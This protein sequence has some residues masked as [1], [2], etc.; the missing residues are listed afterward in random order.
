MANLITNRL[1]I[2]G[3]NEQIKEVFNFI[4][5]EKINEDQ[6]DKFMVLCVYHNILNGG[7]SK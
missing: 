4:K 5:V 1:K 3:S 7:Y 6:H 2:I